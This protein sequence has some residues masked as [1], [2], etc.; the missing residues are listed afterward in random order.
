MCKGLQGTRI[1]ETPNDIEGA[2]SAAVGHHGP[3]PFL[4]EWERDLS[5][6]GRAIQAARDGDRASAVKSYAKLGNP[7]FAQVKQI[8]PALLAMRST[9]EGERAHGRLRF[10]EAMPN[11]KS[12]QQRALAAFVL[13]A[14]E[15]EDD[16][17]LPPRNVSQ[18]ASSKATMGRILG[19]SQHAINGIWHRRFSTLSELENAIDRPVPE[20]VFYIPVFS[21]NVANWDPERP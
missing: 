21:V 4:I 9:D 20:N 12:R 19:M 16:V 18:D 10:A 6:W 17:P 11:L 5:E 15:R 14:T 7:G 1:Q 3:Y 8:G 2:A 13:R